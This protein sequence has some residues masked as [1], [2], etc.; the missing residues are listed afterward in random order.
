M[1]SAQAVK[2]QMEH[3]R[4]NIIS[5]TYIQSMVKTPDGYPSEAD[6]QSAYEAHKSTLLLPRQYKLQQIYIAAPKGADQAAMGK[7]RAKLDAVLKSL[8]ADKVDFAAIARAQSDDKRSA[9]NG[10]DMGWL[11][12]S[13]IPQQLRTPL[14][15]MSKDSISE[16]IQLDDGWH[17]IKLIEV[18]EPAT[19]PLSQIH[20]QIA[21]QLRL[22]RVQTE[23]Q[24]YLEK[25]LQQNP[26]NINESALPK[27]FGKSDTA[28]T[29]PLS[30]TP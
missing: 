14:T 23:R 5:E 2:D 25:L 15:A 6:V 11:P 16:P 10:G 3:A 18:K 7:S 27:V 13:G 22:I 12:E 19:P 1:G 30:K 28:S 20:D 21:S 17:I 4:M 9:A 24:A 8:R 29:T 26:V